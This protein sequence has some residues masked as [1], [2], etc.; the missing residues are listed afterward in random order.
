MPVIKYFIL[1]IFVFFIS[2]N[3]WA[4]TW[5]T[6]NSSLTAVTPEITNCPSG[7]IGVPAL[8]PY[9]VRYFCV[10]KYEMK[11][12]GYGAAV[13]VATGTPWASINRA[14]ARSACQ[15]LGAGFDMIS[16]DQWQT[17]ARNI[18]GVASN[19]NTGTV[20][21]GELNRGHSDNSPANSLAASTDDNDPCYGTEQTCSSSIWDS[22]RRTH[23]LSNGNV[24][25]DFA[26]NVQEWVTNDNNVSNGASGFIAKI[27]RE[28]GGDIRQTSYGP[29]TSTIC[30]NTTSNPYCGIGYGHFAYNFGAVI[31]GRSYLDQFRSGV[32]AA[33]LSSSAT[34]TVSA[35]N[36]AVIGFRCVFVP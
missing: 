14:T 11:N 8:L 19:W 7:F 18:A 3:N 33:D 36:G 10:A 35:A 32:F 1:F 15:N 4:G 34:A 2:A 22:Q 16:N 26:G 24:I 28:S 17:I 25:W 20:A 5:K 23:T 21:S 6:L 27:V 31:R 29:E 12:N 13:S 30:S 9:T